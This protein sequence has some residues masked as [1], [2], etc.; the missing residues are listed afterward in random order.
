[1]AIPY[2]V[3][4][5]YGFVWASLGHPPGDPPPFP[6]WDDPSFRKVHAGPY[7]FHASGFRA[8]ENFVDASHFPYVHAYLNGDPEHPDEIEEYTVE[9]TPDGLKTSEIRVTQYYADARG[10]PVRAG[11]TYHCFRPLTAYFSKRTGE[12][13]RFCTF[14]TTTPVGDTESIVW[15]IVAI[16]FGWDMPEAQIHA[17]QD[18][19]FGQDRRIVETQRPE[20]IPLDLHAELHVR[21][22]K[23]AVEYRKWLKQLGVTVGAM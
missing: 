4:E 7:P 17:R 2:A 15:L 8:V 13:E 19:I 23:L 11:Y 1:Q 9:M 18:I 20:R 3:T 21:S 10:T 16:N 14:L 6:E 12:R 22:D 5:R